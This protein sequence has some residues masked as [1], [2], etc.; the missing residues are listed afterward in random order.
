MYINRSYDKH[1][2]LIIYRCQMF[3]ILPHSIAW[4]SPILIWNSV[5]DTSLAGT[6]F[7]YLT[8]KAFISNPLICD[9]FL[10][11]NLWHSKSFWAWACKLCLSNSFQFLKLFSLNFLCGYIRISI[12]LC[13]HVCRHKTVDIWNFQ[14]P[15]KTKHVMRVIVAISVALSFDI[16]KNNICELFMPLQFVLYMCD[17]CATFTHKNS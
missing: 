7:I 3:K 4:G 2:C 15:V 6:I 10:T 13:S 12:F 17:T 9:K 8:P 16:T 5:L 11:F 14:D 1:I